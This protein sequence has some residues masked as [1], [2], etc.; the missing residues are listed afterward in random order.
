MVVQARRSLSHA[1]LI[2]RVLAIPQKRHDKADVA[3]LEPKEVEALLAVPDPR[4]WEGRRDHALIALAVQT[5]LRLLEWT[6]LNCGDVVLG[7]GAHVRSNGKDRK[8]R[9]VR[10]TSA[11]VAAVRVWLQERKGSRDQPLFPTRTGRRLS[12][13]AVEARLVLYKPAAARS[14]PSLAAKTLT[15]HVLRHYGDDWVM[16]LAGVFPLTGLPRVPIP[17]T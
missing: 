9:C 1:Q 7:S 13:D 6:G 10:L 14:C 4:R 17:A 8:Q 16:W 5:G 3:F 2:A 11:N 12:D 15:P